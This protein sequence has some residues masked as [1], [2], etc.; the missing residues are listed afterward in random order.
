[1]AISTRTYSTERRLEMVMRVAGIDYQFSAA[2][3]VL[4]V[5]RSDMLQQ[6]SID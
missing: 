2:A 3:M 1:M 5:T 4:S 6:R